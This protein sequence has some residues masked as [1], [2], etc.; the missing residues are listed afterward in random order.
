MNTS[1][2]IQSN[3]GRLKTL[4]HATIVHVILLAA[5]DRF[6]I[7]HRAHHYLYSLCMTRRLVPWIGFNFGLSAQHGTKGR[8]TTLTR[9]HERF[10]G[11]SVKVEIVLHLRRVLG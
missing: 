1:S 7:S 8:L 2:R 10:K 4:L 3:I 11:I 5:V 6:P 9:I